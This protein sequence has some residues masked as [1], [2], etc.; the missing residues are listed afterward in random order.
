MLSSSLALCSIHLMVLRRA[1]RYADVVEDWDQSFARTFHFF[2]QHRDH[3][4]HVR[5]RECG[6]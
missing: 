3:V 2:A 5:I 6:G 4:L 1:R